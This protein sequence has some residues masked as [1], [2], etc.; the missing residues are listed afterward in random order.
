MGF[1]SAAP[2]TAVALDDVSV[3]TNHRGDRENIRRRSTKSP[4][5]GVE[6][7]GNQTLLLK[8]DNKQ[9]CTVN[10]CQFIIKTVALL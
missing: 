7:I 4:M 1:P 6:A 2:P 8:K 10:I 3:V 9:L 5:G